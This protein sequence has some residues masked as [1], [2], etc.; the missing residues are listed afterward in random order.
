MEEEA[1]GSFVALIPAPLCI[2]TL[3]L[4]DG[5]T[6]KGLSAKPTRHVELKTSPRSAAGGLGSAAQPAFRA[7]KRGKAS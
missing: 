3:T 7:P 2:G 5:R 4:A 6:V 1:L